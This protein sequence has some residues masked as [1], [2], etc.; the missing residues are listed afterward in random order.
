MRAGCARPQFPQLL[1]SAIQ[2][3]GS[4]IV[5]TLPMAPREDLVLE[6]GIADL[7]CDEL[8]LRVVKGKLLIIHKQDT[9]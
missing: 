9:E 6:R 5:R 4:R 7:G 8:K 3:F 1:R 2:D